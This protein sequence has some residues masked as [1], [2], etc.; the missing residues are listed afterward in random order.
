MVQISA[1]I[2]TRNEEQRIEKCLRHLSWVDEIV[3]V[4][5]HSEDRTLAIC[6][7]YTDRVYQRA[8]DSFQNQKNYALEMARGDWILSVDADEII[9]NELRDEILETIKNPGPKKGFLI[10]RANYLLKKPVRYVW[11][12]DIFLRLFMKTEGTFVGSVHEKVVVDGPVGEILRPLFHYNSDSLEEFIQKNNFYTSFEAKKK[13]ESGE[14]FSS[15]KAILAPF[16]IFL[17]RY[18]IL[19]GYRDGSLGLILSVLLAIFNFFVH[20]KL[21]HLCKEDKKGKSF[22][23]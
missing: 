12:K 10:S 15:A 20:L 7:V 4:D 16:R 13:Y 3:V 5:S 14:R 17:F 11:G 9:G 1:I 6:K 21:W 23:C 18:L 2:I 22:Q 8:F 19:K